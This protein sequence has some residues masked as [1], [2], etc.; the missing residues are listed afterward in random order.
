MTT[1]HEWSSRAHWVDTGGLRIAAHVDGDG[2][3]VTFVHGYPSSSLDIV[4]VIERLPTVRW[5]T[6]DLPG[7]GASDK[8]VGHPHTMAA[9]ADAVEAVWRDAGVSSTTL[10]AHDYGATVAQEL[11]ARDGPVDVT[12]VVW[13]NGGVYPDLHRPTLGQ[14]MLLDPV[15]GAEVAAA[16]DEA[17]LRNGILGTWGTR[18]PLTDEIV[19]GMWEAMTVNDGS[20]Q[21]HAMLHYIA[22]RRRF[23]ERWVGAMEQCSAPM[24][25][26]WG[27][28]DP[29]SGAHMAD[30]IGE[31]IPHA[32][33]R[34][35][36]DVGHWPTL[37]APDEVAAATVDLLAG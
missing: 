32:D 7:F 23:A 34:R 33:L 6:L 21:L 11:V 37:E 36:P 14:Q 26:V 35:L 20:K 4:P 30:R 13:M 9:A 27:D 5:I 31:R 28:L 15:H 1:F 29:V 17:A 25:F 2:P 19:H 8:P 24:V 22:E 16:M 3:V 18:V 12:G 10:L